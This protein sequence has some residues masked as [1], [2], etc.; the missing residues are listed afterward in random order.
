M[1]FYTY[2]LG[3]LLLNKSGAKAEKTQNSG[4]IQN[5]HSN[6]KKLHAA[7]QET[8]NIHVVTILG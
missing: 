5:A 6:R 1:N 3:D 8:P 4:L 7:I 2:I